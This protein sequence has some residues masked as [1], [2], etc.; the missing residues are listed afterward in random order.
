MFNE[1]HFLF[2][3][4]PCPENVGAG[5]DFA[6]RTPQQLLPHLQREGARGEGGVGPHRHAGGARKLVLH[7]AEE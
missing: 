4:L 5:G 1:V 2:H 3:P 7:R 6:H